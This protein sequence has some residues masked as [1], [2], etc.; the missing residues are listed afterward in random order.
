[1][2]TLPNGVKVPDGNDFVD[3]VTLLP[4]LARSFSD[5]L[6]GLGVGKR[7]PR[8]F[9]VAN[10]TEKA[11]LPSLTTLID[12][13]QV[14]VADTEWWERRVDGDWKLWQT[15]K[16]IPW[17]FAH[18]S[19]VTGSGVSNFTYSVYGDIVTLTGQFQ[20]LG[21]SSVNSNGSSGRLILPFPAATSG[22]ASVLGSCSAHDLST[23]GFG[24]GL[25]VGSVSNASQALVMFDVG[26]SGMSALHTSV[27]FTWAGGDYIGL[28][29][30]YKRA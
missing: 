26:G 21:G 28:N 4:E 29:L 9:A 23:G 17:P 15:T 12:G 22:L 1:M 30:R 16:G 18:T 14:Y 6:G 19:V 3:P 24:G 27:P 20:L 11:S 13:D 25:V 10:Q 2:I 7:Q 5:A 8:V